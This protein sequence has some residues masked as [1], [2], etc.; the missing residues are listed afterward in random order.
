M[1]IIH[2]ITTIN[3]GGAENQLIQNLLTQ[4]RKG[5]N[6]SVIFL[7]GNG[8]WEKYL[9]KKGIKVYGPF[10]NKFYYFN[11]I[12]ILQIFFLVYKENIILHCHM[13]P[14]LLILYI[15]SI[16]NRKLKIVYT[17]HNDE[18]FFPFRLFDFYLTKL[19][20]Q[21]TEYII[22]ITST[23][24]K[25]LLKRYKLK[26]SKIK[27]IQYSFESSIYK[28]KNISQKELSFYNSKMIYIGTVAR[29]VPQ[30]RID[31]LLKSFNKLFL[32]NDKFRLVV[33]GSGEEKKRLMRESEV[34][35]L[36]EYINWIDY[37]EFVI[38]H[39]RNWS[40]FTLTS[41]YEGFG[42]VLLEAIFAKIP[43]VAM[44]VSSIKEIVGPCGEI[45]KFGD[46]EKFA[47]AILKVLYSQKNYYSNS[48]NHLEKFSTDK[49]F[50]KHLKIYEN[51]L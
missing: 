26:F 44:N 12:G 9:T 22:C 6:V 29:L 49:N 46:Y 2:I 51:I 5:L 19:I 43:I 11:I 45:V 7:K 40:L 20:L 21:R 23:V 36:S 32:K 34:F 13:P 41:E 15:C 25:Y 31:L 42:L 28:N 39:M 48:N 33:I 3:R 16:F 8:Y 24:K 38:D 30:K 10:F 37:T 4:K 18:P 1:N 35:G 27:V 17:S 47:E 50:Q 14:S